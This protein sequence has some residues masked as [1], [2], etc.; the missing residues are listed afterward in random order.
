ME[1]PFITTWEGSP[2]QSAISVDNTDSLPMIP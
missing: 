1:L 2:D